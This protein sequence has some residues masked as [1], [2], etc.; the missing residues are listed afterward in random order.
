M[1]I[2]S[3]P[4]GYHF[5]PFR[6]IS[7]CLLMHPQFSLRPLSCVPHRFLVFGCMSWFDLWAPS[8]IIQK[9]LA[10]GPK[11][12]VG[13]VASIPFTQKNL[14]D[15]IPTHSKLKR[16]QYG[17]RMSITFYPLP[18][19]QAPLVPIST[20]LHTKQQSWMKFSQVKG[21]SVPPRWSPRDAGPYP[22]RRK[23]LSNC[24]RNSP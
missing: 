3:A 7:T 23:D 16:E 22:P 8:K 24:D 11:E 9:V 18:P 20:H 12:H 5:N 1:L 14:M 21:T 6:I 19:P 10:V 15:R 4:R 2:T 17:T 13:L